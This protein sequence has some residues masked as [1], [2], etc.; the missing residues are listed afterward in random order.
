MA[1]IDFK[2]CI[3]WESDDYIVINKPPFVS[4]LDD[5]NDQTTILSLA[6]AYHADAQLCHR[7]DKET[8]GVLVIAKNPDAYRHMSLQFENRTVKKEYHAVVDGIH[9][10]KEVRYSQPIYKM[11]NGS[12]K[13]DKR[14]K[15]AVTY[16]QTL[17]AYKEHTLVECRPVTGRMHQIRIHLSY[18]HAPITGDLQYG[19][20]PL[21]LSNIKRNYNLKKGT[22]ELPLIKRL[23]LHAHKITIKLLN[24]EEKTFEA[25]RPKD[26]KVLIKQLEKNS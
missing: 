25:E 11:S 23:A 18:Q 5:R 14:G 9:D 26:F 1:K 4:S 16:F 24:D 13:I 15:D 22:E 17:K 21:L 12:V 3:I 6:R 7:L 19:G 10:Y 2:K 20:R 8:S